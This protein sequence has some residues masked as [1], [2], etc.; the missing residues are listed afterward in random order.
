MSYLQYRAMDAVFPSGE[1]LGT[2]RNAASWLEP[3]YQGFR[4]SGNPGVS[5]AATSNNDRIV[6]NAELPCVRPRVGNCP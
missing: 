6:Q 3:N 4:L 5:R 1:D 2:L